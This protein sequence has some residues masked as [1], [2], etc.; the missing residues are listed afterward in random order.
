MWKSFGR[1]Y[2]RPDKK[3]KN[4]SEINLEDL[5]KD[6]VKGIILDL[7]DTLL[8]SDKRMNKDIIDT[9]LHKAKSEF[10]LFVVSNNNR[11][12]YV[13]KFCEKF[14][15]P[16]V[17]RATKPRRKFLQIALDKMNLNKKDVII[18]GDRVTTDILA[19][20]R[21]GIKAFL[22]APLTEMPSVFQKF[23]YKIEAYVLKKIEPIADAVPIKEGIKEGIK[24]ERAKAEIKADMKK[25]VIN[26]LTP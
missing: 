20:K 2:F 15:I 12:D 16:F 1:K 8:P 24:E 22:V 18:I 26:D 3:F 9:W 11:H 25:P 23:I 13:K 14:N 10:S 21:F 6:G 4:V 5:K 19:G 7:D 17:A